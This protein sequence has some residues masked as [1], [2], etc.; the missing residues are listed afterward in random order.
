MTITRVHCDP[1]PF[2]SRAPQYLSIPDINPACMYKCICRVKPEKGHTPLLR[3]YSVTIHTTMRVTM[4]LPGY[5]IPVRYTKVAQQ[6]CVS[7]ALL[8]RF[9]CSINFR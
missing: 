6:K 2:Y 9:K 1:Y 5:T 4:T 8:P 7:G 3:Y